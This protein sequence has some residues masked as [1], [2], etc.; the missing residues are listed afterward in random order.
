MGY[1]GFYV[2]QTVHFCYVLLSCNVA[3][4]GLPFSHMTNQN[5]V[6]V[7]TYPSTSL[8]STAFVFLFKQL[9]SWFMR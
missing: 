2:I 7:S 9:S 1:T 3:G 5:T 4:A 6:A 8:K